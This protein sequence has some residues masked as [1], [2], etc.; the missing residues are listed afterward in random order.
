MEE[1]RRH[2]NNL[3]RQLINHVV[4]GRKGLTALD[5]GC[6]FGGDLKKWMHNGVKLHCCDPDEDALQEA[7]NR[8]QGLNYNVKFFKG[9]IVSVP[10]K[11]YNLICYNFSI[12]YCFQNEKLFWK[13][14]YSICNHLSSGGVLF[15]CVPDS[16]MVLMCTP[17]RDNLGN[18]FTRKSDTGMGSFG[19]K[20][21]VFLEDTPYYKDGPKPEPIAY[22]DILITAL[23]TRGLQKIQWSPMGDTGL[24]SMYSQFI[25]VNTN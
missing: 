19:E 17:Y 4:G 6:G 1:L 15:G 10:S 3:K 20:V 8:S 16:E 11:K 21:Y 7:V 9:D 2:H 24:T 22:K 5:V 12:Q 25:F 13:T 18:F 14:I 23:E